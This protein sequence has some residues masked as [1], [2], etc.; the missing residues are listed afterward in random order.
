VNSPVFSGPGILSPQHRLMRQL[1]DAVFDL[2]FPATTELSEP[3]TPPT[4]LPGAKER[5]RRYVGHYRVARHSRHTFFKIDALLNQIPVHDNGDGTLRIGIGRYVEIEPLLFQLIDGQEVYAVFREDA[6]GDIK[7][8]LFGGTGSYEKVPWYESQPFHQ[9]LI[10]IMGL[11]F[12]SAIVFWPLSH[13]IHRRKVDSFPLSLGR[14]I[15]GLVSLLNL[16]FLVSFGVSLFRTDFILFFKTIPPGITVLL[17]I[18][19]LTSLL[20]LS[21]PIFTIIDWKNKEGSLVGRV[22]YTLVSLAAFGFIPFLIYWNLW[23]FRF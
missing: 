3:L 16:V 8:L 12:L 17:V 13:F 19:L 10:V 23:G 15:A 4:P 1:S 18:P 22:H 5:T 11:L 9:R 20:T 6:N 21:L 2:Y 7:Y 14:W